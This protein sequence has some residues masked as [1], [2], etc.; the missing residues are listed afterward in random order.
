MFLQFPEKFLWGTSTAAYQIETAGEH[1]WKGFKS[2]D[3][4]IFDKC[5]MH[6]LRRDE[7][8]EY[9]CQLAPSYRMSMD[10]SKLQKEPFGDFDQKVVAEYTDFLSKLKE[11]KRTIML[12]IHHFTNPLWFETE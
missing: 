7:D 5:S 3:G 4:S 12:V 1:T 9:I 6:D 11:R 2:V 8:L 10:W